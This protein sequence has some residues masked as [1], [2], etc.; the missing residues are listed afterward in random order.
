M[1]V[2]RKE[3]EL[4]DTKRYSREVGTVISDGS[5]NRYAFELIVENRPGV[6]FKI[7]ELFAMKNVNI[8]HFTHS[9]ASY[10]EAAMFVVGDFSGASV[11]PQD[12]YTELKESVPGVKDVKFAGKVSNYFYSKHLF[13]ITVDGN[14]VVMFGPAN[15]SGLLLGLRRNLGYA[16][17]NILEHLGFSVGEEL[18]RYY[19]KSKNLDESNI[20]AILDLLGV[21]LITHGWG[22]VRKAVCE[23]EKIIL[24]VDDLWE[25]YFYKRFGVEDTSRYVLGIINGLFTSIFKKKVVV[26]ESECI[27]KGGSI[28]KFEIHLL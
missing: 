25:C 27:N 8:I 18:Y 23:D 3:Y 2:K 12:L 16:A 28:C 7:G 11:S 9:D 13:P 5:K 24:E 15:I 19:I 14:R 1:E 20:T 22:V 10:D 26:K 4:G 17:P 6:I 21:L